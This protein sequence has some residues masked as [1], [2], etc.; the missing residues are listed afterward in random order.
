L[1]IILP[2]IL[3]L[4]FKVSNQKAKFVPREQEIYHRIAPCVIAFDVAGDVIMHSFTV[5]DHLEHCS[6]TT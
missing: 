6:G 1:R 3:Y 4:K 2:E 5:I